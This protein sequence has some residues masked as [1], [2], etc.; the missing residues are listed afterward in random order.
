MLNTLQTTDI[1]DKELP[2]SKRDLHAAI[3]AFSFCLRAVIS[4]NRGT[5]LLFPR[6]LYEGIFEKRLRICP[7]PRLLSRE[8]DLCILKN[9]SKTNCLMCGCK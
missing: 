3:A 2:L 6:L 9:S 7:L 8:I 1:K 4:E 5:V